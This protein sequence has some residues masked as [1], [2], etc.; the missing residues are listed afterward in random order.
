MIIRR[1]IRGQ[2]GYADHAAFNDF[3]FDI[4]GAAAA[5]LP[6]AQDIISMFTTG[7][8]TAQV[9]AQTQAEVARMQAAAAQAASSTEQTKRT[10]IY[11]G[12]GGVGLLALVL[13]LG[14][15]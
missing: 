15:R 14:K 2:W 9:Q 7:K 12:V 8:S 13:L 10:L 6:A 11:A 5:I 3:G 4:T 1:D